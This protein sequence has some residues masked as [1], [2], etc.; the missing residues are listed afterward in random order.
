[1]AADVTVENL[2][3]TDSS[4]HTSHFA[5]SARRVLAIDDTSEILLI[6]T[7]TLNLFGFQTITAADGASGIQ[8]ARETRPDLILCD[9]NMPNLDGYETLK[10]LREDEATAAI[11][12][13]FLSGATDRLTIRRGMELGADDYLTKPFSP[14]ELLAAVNTRLEKQAELQRR[15]DRKLDELR[16]NITLAL[17]HELRTPLNGIMGL[18]QLLMDDYANMPPEEVLE[19]SRFI[20]DSAMRLHRLIENFLV[21]SQIELMRTESKTLDLSGLARPISTKETISDLARKA[22]ARHKREGD[23]LLKIQPAT[24]LLPPE[25][26]S[27]I[28]EELVDNAFKFSE[29]GKPVLVAT[30]V[31][32]GRVTLSVTD[33]GHGL[34]EDQ[35]RRIGPHTQFDRKTFEQQGAGLGLFISKRLT[36]LLGGELKIQSQ[37]GQLTSVSVSFPVSGI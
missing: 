20:Y 8:L 25:N 19:S 10:R 9:I 28:V 4:S 31:G 6:I 5:K 2:K 11:P 15:S 33:K 29:A 35:I 7:E 12:F 16:G 24:V 1:M 37:P 34:T 21:Y 27:K 17:P 30:Q 32:G 13:V 36:E 23:L 22:A 3:A 14:K 26:F 18:A